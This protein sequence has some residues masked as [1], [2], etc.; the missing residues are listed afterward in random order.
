MVCCISYIVLCTVLYI[1]QYIVCYM[2]CCLLYIIHCVLCV[3][4]Y[5]LSVMYC[6]LY[7]VCYVL[8]I[9]HCALYSVLWIEYYTLCVV[10]YAV[11]Y[12]LCVLKNTLCVELCVSILHPRKN[13][14][15]PTLQIHMNLLIALLLLDVTFI[16]SALLGSLE[17]VIVCQVSAIAL[18]FS[19]LCLFAWMAIEGFNLYRLVVKVFASSA[20]TT[21]RLSILGWGESSC[22]CAQFT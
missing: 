6:I 18:H 14:T 13:K 9:I 7:I 20:I 16:T 17:D 8:Y 3:V 5:R 19:L 12:T 10:L 2:L 4:Y 21:W 15:N 22:V 1:I 11:Y